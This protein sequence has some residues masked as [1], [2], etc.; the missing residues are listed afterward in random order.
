VKYLVD[1]NVLA[2]RLHVASRNREDFKKAGVDFV[3]PFGC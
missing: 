1:A 2:H 3:D